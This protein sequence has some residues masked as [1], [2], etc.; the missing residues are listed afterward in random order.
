MQKPVLESPA[1]AARAPQKTR[2]MKR[3]PDYGPGVRLHRNRRQA[4]VR[5]DGIL[6]TTTFDLHTLPSV[7]QAWREAQRGTAAPV[8]AAGSFAAD[9]ASHVATLKTVTASRAASYLAL[10]IHELGG[11]R[12]SDSITSHEIAAVLERWSVT[13]TIPKP[14]P[15]QGRAS[16]PRGLAAGSLIKRRGYLYAFFQWRFGAAGVNPVRAVPPPA[17][18]KLEARAIPYA[19]EAAP[20]HHVA[21]ILAAMAPHRSVRRGFP[22]V[23]ARARLIAAVIAYTGIPPGML[24]GVTRK[25]LVLT[26]PGSIRVL[27]RLKGGGVEARTYPLG[28]EAFAACVAFDAAGAYGA[29]NIQSVN[30]AF[31]R[32]A[33]QCGLDRLRFHLY[34][35]RHS[36]GTQIYRVTKDARTVERLMGHALNSPM[37]AR[38]TEAAHAEV[39]AAAVA[40]FLPA[41]TPAPAPKQSPK[42]PTKVARRQKLRRIS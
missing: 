40:N 16:A 1:Q 25:D 37:T 27:A 35:L 13:P 36:F 2:P 11:E 31:Q 23:P 18:P 10:W 26:A 42:L 4:F 9:V 41:S 7:I 6:R 15:R 28:A 20:S 8:P 17:A 14:G 30:R 38:Y 22:A 39:D 24:M 29:F 32:A 34:D 19:P 5:V 33:V 12:A 3:S 21:A